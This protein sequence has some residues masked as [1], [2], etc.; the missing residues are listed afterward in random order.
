MH[1][2]DDTGLQVVAVLLSG[3]VFA[4]VLG[5]TAYGVVIA[6]H[7]SGPPL[8]ADG[9]IVPLGEPIASIYFDTSKAEVP[10]EGGGAVQTVKK[11]ALANPRK[12]ILISGYHDPSGDPAKN[13]ELA[14]ARAEAVRDALVAAGVPAERI[15]LRKPEEIPGTEDLQEA[16]R[17]D[18]RLQ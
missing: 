10:E 17:V 4:C 16:R 13:A 7:E 14:R 3:I 6:T 8:A 2:E 9:Q 1:N 15:V 12:T 18:I 5:V 11:K